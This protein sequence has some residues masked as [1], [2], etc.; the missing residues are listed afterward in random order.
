[1]N[2]DQFGIGNTSIVEVENILPSKH[3]LLAKCEFENPTGSQKDRVYLSIIEHL[4]REDVLRPGMTLID[5]SSGNGGM[6]LARLG[7]LKGYNIKIVIPSQVSPEKIRGIEDYGGEIILVKSDVKLGYMDAE[8][9]LKA[10]LKAGKIAQDNGYYFLDQ[11]NNP[12]NRRGC[13]KIGEEI[14]A[15][16]KKNSIELSAFVCGIGTGG[17]ISGVAEILKAS[18]ANIK[19]V[20]VEPYESNTVQAILLKEPPRHGIHNLSG[21]GM[22]S[23]SGN[24]VFEYIDDVILVRQGEWLKMMSRLREE[25][26][27][28]GKTSAAGVAAAQKLVD[29]GHDLNTILTIFFDLAWKYKTE[30][31]AQPA[32]RSKSV[33]KSIFPSLIPDQP[34]MMEDVPDSVKRDYQEKYEDLPCLHLLMDD[35]QQRGINRIGISPFRDL[36][37]EAHLTLKGLKVIGYDDYRLVPGG[38]ECATSHMSLGECTGKMRDLLNDSLGNMTAAI[39][40]NYSQCLSEECLLAFLDNLCSSLCRAGIAYITFPSSNCNMIPL[41]RKTHEKGKR[42]LRTAAD[43]VDAI[44]KSRFSIKALH[45]IAP[46][47]TQ[48]CS[49]WGKSRLLTVDSCHLAILRK[50]FH[51]VEEALESVRVGKPIIVLDHRE[52][53]GD[54]YVASEK[55]TPENI[56]FL[57]NGRGVLCVSM[58]PSKMKDLGI[59]TATELRMNLN[60]TRFGMS[61][62]YLPGCVSGISARDRAATVKAVIMR[63]AK[64]CDFL[65]N[66]HV[67]TLEAMPQGLSVRQGHCEASIELARLAG[68]YPS[69]ATCELLNENGEMMREEQLIAFSE[70]H[71]IPIIKINQIIHYIDLLSKKGS[72]DF[73]CP[74]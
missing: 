37:L 5:F 30:F 41:R 70:R 1:M 35:L 10:R 60:D 34:G 61:I 74:Q 58:L 19:I 4:E 45:P 51:T 39:S 59:T 63:D 50:A 65:K 44:S 71:Q 2:K 72:L 49:I 28:A 36:T 55:A 7:K 14:V 38:T 46:S 40:F 12:L 54:L 68:L 18:F 53:E 56:N 52:D 24:M 13:M 6:A 43:V 22:G 17:T 23:I 27:E 31:M 69:G 9:L 67:R 20:G 73:T 26:N 64:A 42:I 47:E 33:R 29:N 57:L 15:Y 8:D 3:R 25:G 66:G 32:I 21:L 11:A 16:C 48:T 62:D